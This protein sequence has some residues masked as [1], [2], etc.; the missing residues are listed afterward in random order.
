MPPILIFFI[1]IRLSGRYNSNNRLTL[2]KT[3]TDD[4][5]PKLKTHP[6]QDKNDEILRFV[7]YWK[8]RTG[9]LPEELIFDSK[10]TTYK[11]LNKLNKLG[12]DFITLRR[13]SQKMIEAINNESISAWRRIELQEVSRIYRTPRILNQKITLNDYDG[14]IRQMVIADLGHEKLTFLLTNQLTHSAPKLVKRYA[15]R[16]I[17]E[18]NI[19]DGIDFFHMD[20]LSSAVAMKV[21]L[22]LQLTLMASSLYRIF[23]SRI[24][25]GYQNAKSRHIFRDFID[26]TATVIISEKEIVV[27]LQKRSHNPLLIAADFDKIDTPIPW[28]GRKKL[29][30]VFG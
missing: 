11:N 6:K 10:L 30:L 3:V 7:D 16:M 15:E 12:I 29:Q 25:N 18:N 2:S 23:S 20:A 5:N 1:F 4:E 27:R 21:N 14:P 28:L 8:E 17:I 26:A 9:R 24:G 19:E 22:D 13:R